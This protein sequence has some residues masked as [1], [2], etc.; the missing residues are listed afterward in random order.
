MYISALYLYP[1]QPVKS[2]GSETVFKWISNVPQDGR[3]GHHKGRQEEL[4][5]FSTGHTVKV[6][7]PMPQDAESTMSVIQCPQG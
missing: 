6:H 2:A 3:L 5:D 1:K 7:L 4:A